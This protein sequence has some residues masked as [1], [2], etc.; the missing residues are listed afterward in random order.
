MCRFYVFV[1]ST[2]T[3]VSFCTIQSFD[4]IDDNKAIP[5]G[6]PVSGPAHTER[7]MRAG[8][9]IMSLLLYC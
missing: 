7:D 8:G 3:G 4:K 9:R 5:I 1:G 2:F 6:I